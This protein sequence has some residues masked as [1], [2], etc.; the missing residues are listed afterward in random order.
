LVKLHEVCCTLESA[1][2]PVGVIK[3]LDHWPDIGTDLDLVTCSSEA[4][5]GTMEKAFGASIETPMSRI[6]KQL[7]SRASALPFSPILSIPGRC[8]PETRFDG[9]HR[10]S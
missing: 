8:P 4:D 3:S 9:H 1:A 10:F 5:V 2:C 6:R 7:D